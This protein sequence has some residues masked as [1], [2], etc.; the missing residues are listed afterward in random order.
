MLEPAREYTGKYTFADILSWPEDERWELIDGIAYDMTP[1]PSQ[2][3]QEILGA[4][5]A[6]FY[7]FL[8]GAPC[9]VFLAP[10][11]VLLPQ[12]AENAMTTT[13]VV[14]PDL[15]IVCDREKLDGH[16]CVGSPTLV[17]EILSPHTA[18]KDSH[19]KLQKYELVGVQEYWVVY[20]TE[21]IV[22]LFSRD[23]HGRYGSP[24]IYVNGEQIPVGVLP[25]LVINLERVFSE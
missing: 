8:E 9:R 7:A 24:R 2:R 18:R 19:I 13:T 15:T 3:H 25:G 11:D 10:F 4:L 5:F 12:N 6:Q 1:A 16:G 14:Q 23:E 21:K 17:V 20:P 22:Q